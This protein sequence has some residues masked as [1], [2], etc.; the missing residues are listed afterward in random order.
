M[1]PAF[2]VF[3]IFLLVLGVLWPRRSKRIADKTGKVITKAQDKVGDNP[4]S[5]G[6]ELGKKAVKKSARAGRKINKKI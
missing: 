4:V 5:G 6:L 3:C 1:I 2:I